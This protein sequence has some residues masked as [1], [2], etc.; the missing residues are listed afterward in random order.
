MMNATHNLGTRVFL[1]WDSCA[2]QLGFLWYL[3]VNFCGNHFL[4]HLESFILSHF[5]K[6]HANA[7]MAVAHLVARTFT[8]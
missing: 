5:V 4:R 7:Q 6:S 2:T 1:S 8:F 3:R